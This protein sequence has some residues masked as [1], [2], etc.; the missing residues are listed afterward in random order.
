MK[1]NLSHF[2]HLYHPPQR[3]IP[4]AISP[5]SHHPNLL[6][7]PNQ[8]QLH[9]P[10]YLFNH[11]L[12][13]THHLIQLIQTFHYPQTLP[14]L[15]LYHPHYNPHLTPSHPPALIFLNQIPV[16]LFLYHPPAYHSI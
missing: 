16:H 12:H 2:S 14:N 5:I 15:I 6:K 11:L 7:Q 9:L 3:P 10:I 4:H 8:T 13:F 1:T